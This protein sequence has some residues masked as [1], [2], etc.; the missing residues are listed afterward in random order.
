VSIVGQ[1]GIG[2]SRLVDEFWNYVDGLNDTYYWHHGRSPSY[3]EGLSFWAIGEMV[4]QRCGIA[5]GDDDHRTRTRLRTTLA[6]YVPDADDRAWMEPR[7][8]SLL[9]LSEEAVSDR[10]ELFAAWRMLFARVADRG[11]A[12]LILED[13][14]WADDGLLDFID[15]MVSISSEVPILIVTLARPEL[16]ERRQGW[17]SGRTNC[18]STH[19]APL[20]SATMSELVLGV[21][22]D[23][24]ASL[25]D[26]LVEH[27]GGVPLYAVELLRMLLARGAIE[28]VGAGRYRLTAD[29]EDVPIPDSLHGLVGARIDEMSRDERSLIADAAILGQSFTVDGL[30]ALRGGTAEDL[31]QL[32]DPLVRREVLS[33]NRDPRSPERGQYRFVQSIIRE[34]AH[35]RISRADRFDRHV[36]VARYFDSMD[37]PEVAG[38]V[39]T[40][41]LD[42]LEVA[43]EG[44]AQG[45]VRR[46]TIEALL[47]AADRAA[48]LQAHSQVLSLCTRGIEMSASPAERG[49]LLIRATRAAHAGLDSSAESLGRDAVAAFEEAGDGIGRMRAAT[50]LAKHLD[51][52][53][54][55]NEAW[56]ILLEAV[57]ASPGD[58]VDH[59]IAM[60]EL[61]RG[62]ML[63]Q[64]GQEGLA[65]CD[66]ALAVAEPLEALPT[67]A[68]AWITK[69]AG[70]STAYRH[71]E[72][73]V[74][75]EAGVDLARELQLTTTKRRALANLGFVG[76]SDS[77]AT[78]DR[79]TQEGL[80]DARRLGHPRLLAD[81]LLT[82]A[83]D[84]TSM[85][86]WDSFDEVL[87]EIDPDSLTRELRWTY[88]QAVGYRRMLCGH[89]AEEVEAE[90]QRWEEQGEADSQM[91]LTRRLTRGQHA[92]L[93]GRWEE[94]FGISIGL[95]HP[96]PGCFDLSWAV[97][98]ALCLGRREA[99]EEV[100]AKLD[101]RPYRGNVIDLIR[102]TAQAAIAAVDGRVVDAGS[103]FDEAFGLAD[104][105]WGPLYGNMVKVGA[106]RVL[107]LDHPV[108]RQGAR[109]AHDAWVKTQLTT[110][111][112]IH[113]DYLLAAD[114]TGDAAS[115]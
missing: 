108:G 23:A 2:K 58:T 83:G 86:D 5:E 90:E 74:L 104:L 61:G 96:A 84:L 4:R 7:L 29:V 85:L 40:H 95:D 68:E 33:V 60:A 20:A 14:H 15:E 19:L 63:D 28:Q 82:R 50:A 39:A 42:A 21:V 66:R 114:E 79:F 41:Y 18:L 70:L 8:E 54:R 32:L 77:V 57:E 80:D 30:V 46:L 53:G 105:A 11:T 35:Q 91:Q 12:V 62:L 111:L 17:G 76:A 37:L 101:A 89:A 48:A 22:P 34:V 102:T 59:A 109:E 47:A 16:L 103:L 106:A 25:V 88:D 110:L 75:L 78:D 55:S 112:D 44:D 107:G 72:A 67:I 99:F 71:R 49:E 93:L 36:K 1:G 45:E 65:W 6:E 98:A 56:P 100:L 38:V 69:G 52:I 27:S 87:S 115:A 9:G 81:A 13:L 113:S 26:R 92:Y 24:S 3:G 73:M 97:V 94:S 31:T 51:D 10:S 64:H 43:P